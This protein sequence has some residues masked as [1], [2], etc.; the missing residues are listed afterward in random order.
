MLESRALGDDRPAA[1]AAGKPARPRNWEIRFGR[2]MTRE[3][4]AEQLDFFGIELAVVMPGDQLLY[5]REFSKAKPQTRNGPASEERRY[6]LTWR[7]GDLGRA[8]VDLL[9]RAGV[10]ASDRVVLKIIPAAVEAKLAALE[11]TR[12]GNQADKIRKTQFGVRKEGDEYLFFVMDQFR[13]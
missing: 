13:K 7:E 6:Y 8:D 1:E 4:Y 12:A 3:Q 2:G 11:E 10:D 9:A 5:V